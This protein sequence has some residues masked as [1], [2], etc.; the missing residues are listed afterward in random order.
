MTSDNTRKGA[1]KR[2]GMGNG[3]G[4]SAADR[5]AAIGSEYELWH[6]PAQ[7]AYASVGRH[8][9]K[10]HSKPFRSLLI[11]EYRKRYENKVPNAEAVAAAQNAIEGVAVFDG[12]VLVAHVRVA[13]HGGDVYL[14]LADAESTV[15][16]IGPDGWAPCKN[17]PVKFK[18]PA[19]MHALSMPVHGGKIAD[20]RPFLNLAD[21]TTFTLVVASIMGVFNPDGPFPPLVLL[22]EQGS[23]KSTTARVLKRLLDPAAAPIRSQPREGRDLMISAGNNWILAFDN[24]SSIPDWLSDAFCRIAT[25]GGYATRELYSDDGEIIFDSKRPLILNAIEDIIT[26]GDLLERSILLRHPHIPEEKRVPEKDFWSRFEV[27]RPKL[28]GAV[29]D[30]V[31]GG[32]RMLKNVELVRSPRMA[33]FARFAVACE[34]GSGEGG[35]LAAYTENQSGAHEAALDDS[36]VTAVL[37]QFLDGKDGWDGTPTELFTALNGLVSRDDRP[38]G[39]PKRANSLTGKLRRLAPDL[40]RVHRIDVRDGRQ[41]GGKRTRFVSI[42]RLP[43]TARETPSPSSQPSPPPE[44]PVHHGDDHPTPDRPVTDPLPSREDPA[45]RR[46]PKPK[47]TNRDAGDGRDDLF[48]DIIQGQDLSALYH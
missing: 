33:D 45:E 26:R 4:P 30:R 12:H 32:L 6:D 15:I 20:L 7:V 41:P 29:L 27:A 24:L 40:R 22:G 28:L 34:R 35:F 5:L 21:E 19:G 36:P 31:A 48:P 44:T 11:H 25:G 17:P 18:Q 47:Q 2:R 38:D 3:Q 42:T 23:A 14:H 8:S 9:F 39:W 1:N 10:V 16:R 37:L 43:E 46:K 13:G